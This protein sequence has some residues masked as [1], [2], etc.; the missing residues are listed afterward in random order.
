AREPPEPVLDATRREQPL[1]APGHGRHGHD[2]DRERED[3][4]PH[5]DAGEDVE[6][7]ADVDLPEDV[8]RAQ[9]GDDE[10]QRQP[11]RP[12]HPT[13]RACTR[14]SASIASRMSSSACAGDSGT[15]STSARFALYPG[16]TMS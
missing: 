9:A 16:T 1:P 11:K 15:G 8:G 5:T 3:E 14:R 2:H 7:L 12:A 6:R 4:V 13:N 10:R